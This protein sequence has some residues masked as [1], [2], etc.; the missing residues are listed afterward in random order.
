M[1]KQSLMDANVLRGLLAKV[2]KEY[3]TEAIVAWNLR[4]AEAIKEQPDA[5]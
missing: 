4:R 1:S 3:N 5:K 2:P